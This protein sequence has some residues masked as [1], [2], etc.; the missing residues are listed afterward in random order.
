MAAVGARLAVQVV[1]DASLQFDIDTASDLNQLGT[2]RTGQHPAG[3]DGLASAD[4]AGDGA[5]DGGYPM[6]RA[7][8]RTGSS[9]GTATDDR[10]DF[11]LSAV[12][13]DYRSQG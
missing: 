12:L 1:R 2:Q 7:V 4:G 5:G 3:H 8:R 6:A 10:F 9:D 13:P 11:D